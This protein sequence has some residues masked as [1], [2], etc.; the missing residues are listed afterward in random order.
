MP[1]DPMPLRPDHPEHDA[2]A[3][4]DP[5][6][7]ARME[8]DL[9]AQ[10]AAARPPTASRGAGRPLSIA[11]VVV[12]LLAGMGLFLSGYSLGRETATTPGTPAGETEAFQAFW[13]AY[14]A[15]TERYAGGDVDRKTLIEGA[16]KGMFQALGDP[17][18]SYL[19]S[20]EYRDSLRGISGE[21]EGIG[22]Q[23][24]TRTPDGTDGECSPLGPACAL[25][26]TVPLEGSPAKA[27]G[28]LPDDVIV[29]VDG[30]SLD[31]LTVD[32]ARDLIRGPRDTVVKLTIERTGKRLD[33]EVTRAVIVE[34]EVT[35]RTY[36]EGTI[37]YTKLTGFSEHASDEFAR[38][39]AADVAAGRTK[40]ILD[41]RGNPGGFVT[42]AREIASQY[43]AGG[44]VFWQQ[45]AAG[46]LT[47]T[48]AVAGGAATNPDIRLV[49]L[50]DGGSAS[51]SEIVAGALHDRGRATLIGT[52]SFGK[53]T[54][55]QWTPLEGDHGG[56]RLT[57]AK[58]LTPDK[59]WIH[60]HGIEPDIL[61]Q[62]GTGS[63]DTILD[64]ALQELGA[65]DPTG[66]VSGLAA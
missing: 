37:G 16:I 53:G 32:E 62:P 6:P 8:P 46:N 38:V 10:L 15:V 63:E 27:A 11:L 9:A 64:R 25:V 56:F 13:D 2:D 22:A 66:L 34:E 47:E 52:T 55:Q 28:L 65:A 1:S 29:A 26:I 41:L 58:W 5:V 51:A 18:S 50:I 4:P 57:V 59:T 45:D 19:T 14:R 30:E 36:A 17:Y 42:A 48:T 49:V 40:L 43:L 54:V 12:A 3:P 23:I 31:G 21:F 60:G 35:T 7:I 20:T 61:V 33:V 44:T 24:T 39:I